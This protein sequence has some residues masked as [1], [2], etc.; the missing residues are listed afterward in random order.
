MSILSQSDD[1]PVV[2]TD[3]T[4]DAPWS[5]VKSEITAPQTEFKFQ[6]FIT[7]IDDR[8]YD[9]LAVEELLAH[10]PHDST[11]TF[12]FVVDKTTITAPEHPVLVVDLYEDVG[13]TFRVIPSE[14]WTVQNNLS[15]ANMDWDDFADH[16]DEDCV[17]RGLP[18][19]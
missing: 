17:Y 8:R 14:M 16:T 6:P 2:R 15:I 10:T 11:H 12:M 9:G 18:S 1:T 3:F 7:F 4:S 13:R 19:P 5:A